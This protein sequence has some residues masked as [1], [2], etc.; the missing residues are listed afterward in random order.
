[1]CVYNRCFQIKSPE[2]P[3][4]SQYVTT[5]Y[6]VSSTHFV[7]ILCS[8]KTPAASCVYA[9]AAHGAVPRAD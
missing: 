5:F 8:I 9:H 7:E 1:M 6:C 2:F 3:L 4:V